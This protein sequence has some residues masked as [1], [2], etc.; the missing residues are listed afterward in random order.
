MSLPGPGPSTEVLV[1]GASSG[2]GAEIARLLA[3][4]GHNV[5]IV[6]R[7]RERLDALAGELRGAHGVEVD[8]YERDLGDPA[9]R[10]ALI[11]ELG[12]APRRL[13]GLC[14]CAGFGTS[15]PFLELDQ[16]RELGQ[17]ELN[18]TAS[19]HL[20]HAFAT[21]MVERGEGA[22]L[23]VAS[24]AAFQPLPGLA[25][26][27]ATKAFVQS[28]SEA[29]HEEL[30]GTGVSCTVL[31]PGPV[32]TEWAE[33]ADAQAVMLGPAKVSPERVARDAVD[34]M[35]AG[36]RSVIPGLIPQTAALAGRF[37][38]RTVLLP[39]FKRLLRR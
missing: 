28:F 23:N 1:T 5:A 18:I 17:I 36:K 29:F 14:N 9:G 34:G 3:Q 16:Q 7:R 10:A 33:I 24:L 30:R 32:D 13:V 2:I 35:E 26:Y 37:A 4:R 19:L 20:T 38:P 12:A 8:V 27:S 31:C 15:G 22:I 21:G 11:A 25:T 6:A 39:A